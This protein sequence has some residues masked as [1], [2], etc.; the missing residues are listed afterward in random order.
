MPDVLCVVLEILVGILVFPLVIFLGLFLLC[1]LAAY[2][3]WIMDLLD[4]L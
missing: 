4:R 3:E 2:V 1:L